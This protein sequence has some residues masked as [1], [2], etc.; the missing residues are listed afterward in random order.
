VLPIAG[1]Y[2][3]PRAVWEPTLEDMTHDDA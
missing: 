3:D 2:R 1:R